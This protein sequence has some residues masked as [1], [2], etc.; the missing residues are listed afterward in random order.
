MARVSRKGFLRILGGG[1]VILAAGS[2]AWIATRRPDEALAP[3]APDVG[4][5]DP[6]IR[7]LAHAI[8][9]PNP[10]NRQ[11]WR[12]ALDEPDVATLYV[13]L[14]R[15]LPETDP[16]D[17]Q[18]TVGLGAFLEVL[19]VAASADGVRAEIE[20]FPEGAAEQSDGVRLDARPVARI[21]FSP[22]A[23]ADPLAAQILRRRT[24]KE[25]YAMDRPPTEA[26][27]ARVA[28]AATTPGV[29]IAGAV[30]PEA[31]AQIRDLFWRAHEV[32]AYTPAK[33]QESIDLMRIGKAEIEANPD[34]I[35]LGG[36]FL[37]GLNLFGQLDR[38]QLADPQSMAFAQGMDMYR[39]M[40]AATPAVVW[41]TTAANTRRDQLAAGRAFVRAQLQATAMGMSLHPLSQALQEFPE[42]AELYAEAR[43]I[44]GA[45]PGGVVQMASRFGRGPEVDPSPR[46][47]L[48]A[49]LV[50]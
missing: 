46:W 15:R 1:A 29:E 49:K 22:G 48:E 20:P 25:P 26:E 35:D 6:R 38:E 18:I 28:A 19:R 17:R 3:W 41:M 34:G 47:P 12:V 5:D 23:E 39:E 7:A 33:L 11:P 45:G 9:A 31:V 4:G 8:L 16:L 43:T 2:G 50:S 30:A 13:D 14:D 40:I 24:N 21:V 42:M 32:E 27:L 44:F 37:E 10:H 36:P